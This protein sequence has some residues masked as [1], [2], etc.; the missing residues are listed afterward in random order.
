MVYWLV[1]QWNRHQ[2]NLNW[3][4][5]S[6]HFHIYWIISFSTSLNP[7]GTPVS[8]EGSRSWN[9]DQSVRVSHSNLP[10]KIGYRNGYPCNWIS[11]I[12]GGE[13]ALIINYVL[14]FAVLYYS[15]RYWN[16]LRNLVGSLLASM[17]SIAS[18]LVLLFL[19]IV[20]FALLG[21]QIFG[22]RFNFLHLRKPRSNFDNFYQ[23]RTTVFQVNVAAYH[24]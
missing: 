14:Y 8:F 2:D 6:R 20:I 5:N 3:S 1:T 19:F 15:P 9:Q 24:G 10:N 4:Y 21:M 23:A 16:S 18:L 17:R 11:V 12:S 22:G 13:G 7:R